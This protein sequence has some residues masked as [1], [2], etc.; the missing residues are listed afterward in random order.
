MPQLI[1]PGNHDVQRFAHTPGGWTPLSLD[2]E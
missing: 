1:V 2:H